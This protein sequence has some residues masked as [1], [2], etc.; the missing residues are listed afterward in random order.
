MLYISCVS[1]RWA[2]ESLLDSGA[3][4]SFGFSH[5]ICA[6]RSKLQILLHFC[7]AS[8]AV[9]TLLAHSIKQEVPEQMRQ[10]FDEDSLRYL[11]IYL[12]RR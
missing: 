1:S 8:C 6:L 11:L 10:K 7:A 9:P 3:R 12:S 5:S 2:L 4:G